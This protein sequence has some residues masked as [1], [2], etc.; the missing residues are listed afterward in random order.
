MLSL[1]IEPDITI[2]PL[3]ETKAAI[4]HIYI[5]FFIKKGFLKMKQICFSQHFSDFLKPD[6][7]TAVVFPSLKI[8]R[9]G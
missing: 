7:F 2:I 3:V 5:N 8:Y 6:F 1:P 9:K 4:K